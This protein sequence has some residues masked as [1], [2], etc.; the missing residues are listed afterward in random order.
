MAILCVRFGGEVIL[1]KPLSQREEYLRQM[2]VFFFEYELLI[3]SKILIFP[4]KAKADEPEGGIQEAAAQPEG[5]VPEAAGEGEGREERKE[6]T[7]EGCIQ[8]LLF[9]LI[10]I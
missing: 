3:C 6:D 2:K 1:D 10:L 5:R 9:I 7:K 4:V 8:L